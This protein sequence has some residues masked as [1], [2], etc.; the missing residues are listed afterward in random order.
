MQKL[1]RTARST[2]MALGAVSN[3]PRCQQFSTFTHAKPAFGNPNDQVI[4]IIIWGDE[5]PPIESE[6]NMNSKEP[7]PLVAIDQWSMANE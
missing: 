1:V 5:V 2:T 6:E 4:R 3:A 7:K